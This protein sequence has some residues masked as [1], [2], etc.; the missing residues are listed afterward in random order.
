MVTWKPFP[1]K[2]FMG[3]HFEDIISSCKLPYRTVSYA[4]RIT[5]CRL[6]LGKCCF[7]MFRRFNTI[8]NALE[9][10]CQSR[11]HRPYRK[12]PNSF[13]Q[14]VWEVDLRSL[15]SKKY[16]HCH[17]TSSSFSDLAHFIPSGSTDWFPTN[18]SWMVLLENEQKRSWFKDPESPMWFWFPRCWGHIRLVRCFD[19]SNIPLSF[20]LPGP[21]LISFNFLI[22]DPLV[23]LFW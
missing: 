16:N 2:S 15:L 6:L 22:L 4:T 8:A 11:L 3:T 7:T 18:C 19:A 20:T 23:I 21:S 1:T 14:L 13:Y 12:K 10:A 9:S 17:C 5:I